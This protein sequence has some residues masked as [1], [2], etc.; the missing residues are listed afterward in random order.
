MPNPTP[1]AVCHQCANPMAKGI[2]TCTPPRPPEG[3]H[4]PLGCFDA[5]EWAKEFCKITGFKDLDWARSWFA[6]AIMTGHDEAINR[7]RSKI[8]LHAQLVEALEDEHKWNIGQS[9]HGPFHDPFICLVC[10]LLREAAK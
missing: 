3:K 5:N 10:A 4:H 8:D 2:H 9:K 6:S 7:N 1:R